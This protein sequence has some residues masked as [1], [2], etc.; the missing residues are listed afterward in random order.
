MSSLFSSFTSAPTINITLNEVESREKK[1]FKIPGS[2]TETVEF[3][4][5]NGN[6]SVSG[7]IDVI[8]QAGKKYEHLGIKVEMIGQI[9]KF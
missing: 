9:G 3:P 4:I 5:Y 7:K 2:T 1:V 6:E 8:V